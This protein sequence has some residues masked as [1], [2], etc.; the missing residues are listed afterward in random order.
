MFENDHHVFSRSFPLTGGKVDEAGGIPYLGA[1]A[2]SV[3]VRKV[4]P[5]QLKK[6]PWIA[7]ALALNHLYVVEVTGKGWSA[8]AKAADGTAFDRI[9]RPWRR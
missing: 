6:R 3:D 1:G 9:E 4:D 5:A 2:W 8:E 7:K